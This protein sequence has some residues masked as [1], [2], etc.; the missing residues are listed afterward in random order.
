MDNTTI[1]PLKATGIERDAASTGRKDVCL[2]SR[3]DVF[4][5][6]VGA[7]AGVVNL[8][9]VSRTVF[10]V[11]ARTELREKW[12][13]QLS[14]MELFRPP[15][16]T[17]DGNLIGINNQHREIVAFCPD[18]GAALWKLSLRNIP[19]PAGM[20]NKPD[21][22][23]AIDVKAGPE[24]SV[25]VVTRDSL[26]GGRIVLL[27]SRNGAL[28]GQFAPEKPVWA[29]PEF[30]P[31]GNV[32][33]LDEGGTLYSIDGASGKMNWRKESCLETWD[34]NRPGASLEVD[35]GGNIFAGYRHGDVIMFDGKTGA[36]V[37][38]ARFLE[39]FD[40][41][42]TSKPVVGP[43][44][45]VYVVCR[46]REDT[47]H[48]IDGKT[49]QEMVHRRCPG[50]RQQDGSP[51]VS[52][53]DDGT[54]F[55]LSSTF[56]YAEVIALDPTNGMKKWGKA[57][58]ERADHISE[59]DKKGNVYIAGNNSIAVLEGATGRVLDRF[60]NGQNSA[61]QPVIASDGTVFIL[62]DKGK[63]T[64]LKLVSPEDKISSALNEQSLQK[65]EEE[66]LKVEYG[67]GVVIIGGVILPVRRP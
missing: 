36:E 18:S 39:D 21:T 27:D 58:L 44:G 26:G 45:N 65:T 30:D 54:V 38:H 60:D 57:P 17:G 8:R 40:I 9:E 28:K 46:E 55:A 35:K 19:F 32:V 5:K 6:T 3:Q 61:V 56:G 12:S 2:S 34:I 41:N 22:E 52:F 31:G 23:L 15:A 1:R 51:P 63:L 50:I 53:G 37:N 20:E 11:N 62:G 42:P 64:A 13:I 24:N 48:V 25:C 14:G 33:A 16:V 67:S 29:S 59:V 47:M 66:G 49:G 4:R 10:D 7:D 43:D